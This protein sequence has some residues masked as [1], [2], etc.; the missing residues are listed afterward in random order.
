[1][2][3]FTMTKEPTVEEP[4]FVKHLK[5]PLLVSHLNMAQALQKYTNFG[6][7]I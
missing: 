4:V 6:N 1:M 7:I 3:Q 2:T 5:R